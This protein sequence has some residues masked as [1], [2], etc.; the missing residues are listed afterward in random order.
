MNK[1]PK[2]LIVGNGGR[3]ASIVKNISSKF[4]IY[5]L[6]TNENPTI[7][8]FS[9]Q[10][11]VVDNFILDNCKNI[12]SNIV[13][14]NNIQYGIVQQDDLLEKGYI[15]YMKSINLKT[16]G[17][18]RKE[19]Q[20]EWDKSFSN[21]LV[22]E[23]YKPLSNEVT[24]QKEI[25]NFINKI[26]GY[27]NLVVKPLRLTGGKGVKV[28]SAHFSSYEDAL[29]YSL[30]NIK[31]DGSVLL[32]ERIYD[33]YEFTIM[34]FTNGKEIIFSP[35]TYDYPY[36][37]FGDNGPGTGGMGCVTTGELLPFLTKEDMEKCHYIMKDTLFKLNEKGIIFNGCLNGGFFKTKDNRILFME[38]NARLGDPECLNIMEIFEEFPNLMKDI[39]DGNS[40]INYKVP[41]KYSYVHY[42]TKKSYCEENNTPS[43]IF[44]LEDTNNVIFANCKA[45]NNSYE[46]VGESRVFAL[47]FK[48]ISIQKSREKSLKVLNKSN[49]YFRNDIGRIPFFNIKDLSF[50]FKNVSAGD[51]YLAK[52]LAK[53][54]YNVSF[55]ENIVLFEED[56][57]LL[58]A[59][60]S[61]NKE[62]ISVESKQ[63]SLKDK[64]DFTKLFGC[65]S[66][67]VGDI[68]DS[69]VFKEDKFII[70]KDLLIIDNKAIPGDF[71]NDVLGGPVINY[72]GY[73]DGE[74]FNQIGD[75]SLLVD[76]DETD[77]NNVFINTSGLFSN[78]MKD[79]TLKEEILEKCNH[80]LIKKQYEK[81]FIS[82]QVIN[83][84]PIELDIGIGSP[85]IF[86]SLEYEQA[87]IDPLFLDYKNKEFGGFVYDD[88]GLIKT[89]NNRTV[90][91]LV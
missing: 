48:D 74:K 66:G 18:T 25:E 5:A 84:T 86:T 13:K 55:E 87:T 77:Q 90:F 89:V 85:E 19:S 35:P 14:E 24:T 65:N 41:N 1:K 69:L 20:I 68:D 32:Q 81:C 64:V 39:C 54:G 45:V 40:I 58:D 2:I 7:K 61:D 43:V 62:S 29:N 60:V 67:I 3:E 83:E 79:F 49:L 72:F 31:N 12:I 71:Y 8:Q 50:T 36:R 16:F 21:N 57:I 23:N 15:D 17:A 59:L 9:E 33:G 6:V 38:Y 78:K 75:P 70:R 56:S 88:N 10:L 42:A 28:G 91:Y 46:T 34:G 63:F 4:N 82:I 11:Y 47:S 30:E 51:K 22:E 73:F 44:S 26:N 52:Q 80:Y 27:E 37:D 53:Y 76:I